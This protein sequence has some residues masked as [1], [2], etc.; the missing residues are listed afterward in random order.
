MFGIIPISP[1]EE[2][3]RN[4]ILVFRIYLVMLLIGLFIEVATAFSL[5]QNGG[6]IIESRMLVMAT[7]LIT[8]L[9]G[10]LNI[11]LTVYLIMWLRRA[12]HNLHKA[13]SRH[14]RHSEGWAAGAWFVPILNFF[15]PL[16]IVRD[17]W[18][19]TQNVFRK[20]GEFY[21]RKEDNITGWWWALFLIA[22]FVGYIG[23]LNIQFKNFEAGYSF[24]ALSHAGYIF[25]GFLLISII[26]KISA[27]E[28]QMMERAHQYYA[29]LNQQQ[30]Q[31]FREQNSGEIQ[32]QQQQENFYRPDSPD[33]D[34]PPSQA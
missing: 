10:L 26:R 30:A 8:V 17:T 28:T 3:S 9:A 27:M 14:L 32:N 6:N 2:R 4:L 22:I 7:A 1:N 23:S 21:E 12:Y 24:S 34:I 20:Q 31:N 5:H 11:V 18:R 33:N 29:W 19:E 13:G 15:W 25:S 16:Q